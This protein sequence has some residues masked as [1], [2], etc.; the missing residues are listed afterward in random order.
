MRRI[1]SASKRVSKRER[2]IPAGVG[3]LSCLHS[4]FRSVLN[5]LEPILTLPFEPG[6]HVGSDP[7]VDSKAKAIAIIS[8]DPGIF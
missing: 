6:E 1:P 7:V 5:P 8:E 2:P 4:V 3:L